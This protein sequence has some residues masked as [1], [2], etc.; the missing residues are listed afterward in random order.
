MYFVFYFNTSGCTLFQD[1]S[2]IIENVRNFFELFF[3][4][5]YGYKKVVKVALSW[6][7]PVLIEMIFREMSGNLSENVSKMSGIWTLYQCLTPCNWVKTI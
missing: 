2:E 6:E 5:Y 7:V 3:Q 4:P 1:K